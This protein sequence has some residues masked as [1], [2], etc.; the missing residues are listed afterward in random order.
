MRA[1]GFLPPAASG[2][3]EKLVE[4]RI[5]CEAAIAGRLAN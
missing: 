5:G 4:T 2:K 3:R 1:L